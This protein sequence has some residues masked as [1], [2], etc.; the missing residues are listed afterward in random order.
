MSMENTDGA[1][2]RRE[3]REILGDVTTQP[4]PLHGRKPNPQSPYRR[5]HPFDHERAARHREHDVARAPVRRNGHAEATVHQVDAPPVQV[6]PRRV[7]LGPRSQGDEPDERPSRLVGD[8]TGD[9]QRSLLIV[10]GRDGC[11]GVSNL[12]TF[13]GHRRDDLVRDRETLDGVAPH[14]REQPGRGEDDGETEHEGRGTDHLAL[15]IAA[16]GRRP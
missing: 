13:F 8:R 3:L 15:I 10:V 9:L 7:V 6:V 12:G 1:N 14:R 5:A 11:G 2:H 16:R 4:D